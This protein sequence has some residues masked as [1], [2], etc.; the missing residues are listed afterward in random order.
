MMNRAL[1]RLTVA[2]AASCGLVLGGLTFPAQAATPTVP[3]ANAIVIPSDADVIHEA[4]ASAHSFLPGALAGIA[5]GIR[6]TGTTADGPATV[7]MASGMALLV[8]GPIM[9]AIVSE[10]PRPQPR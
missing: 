1:I 4:P 5:D 9:A 6:A 3:A 7:A 10:A 2:V 8:F